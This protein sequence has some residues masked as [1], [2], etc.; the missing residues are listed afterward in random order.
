MGRNIAWWQWFEEAILATV[1][2]STNDE[3]EKK[4]ITNVGASCRGGGCVIKRNF[5]KRPKV[6]EDTTLSLSAKA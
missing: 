5:E 6:F 4:T 2:R 1:M 3:V